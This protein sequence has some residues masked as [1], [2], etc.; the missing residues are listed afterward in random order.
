MWQGGVDWAL[1]LWRG[2]RTGV[3]ML[4]SQEE[5][6]CVSAA[7]T[8]PSLPFPSLPAPPQTEDRTMTRAS[9]P[10]VMRMRI[11]IIAK[12]SSL[13]TGEQLPQSIQCKVRS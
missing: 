5:F 4:V 9:E 1:E 10:R 11:L 3:V 12:G 2:S 8:F 7:H 13:S 6:A